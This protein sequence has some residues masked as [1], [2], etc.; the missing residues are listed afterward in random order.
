[1][2]D[3]AVPIDEEPTQGETFALDEHAEELARQIQ[4]IVAAPEVKE[5]MQAAAACA[6]RMGESLRVLHDAYA[7][8]FAQIR[9]TLQDIGETDWQAVQDRL[10]KSLLRLADVGWTVPHWL[11]PR[12][13]SEIAQGGLALADE[14]FLELYFGDGGNTLK[15]VRDRLLKSDRMTNWKPLLLQTVAALQ[16]G[17]HLLAVPCFLLILEGYVAQFAYRKKHSAIRDTNVPRLLGG[18][19][20]ERDMLTL[21]A[22]WRSTETFVAKLFRSADFSAESPGFINRHWI[23]HGR[24][25]TNWTRADALRLLNALDT[26]DWLMGHQTTSEVKPGLV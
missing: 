21:R 15:E 10:D 19:R 5:F 22:V 18:L 4:E 1:M 7:D 17:E 13:V 23:L 20:P 25:A 8:A 12:E 16:R 26:L 6:E 24:G 2:V 14:H 3:N 11:T 9:R